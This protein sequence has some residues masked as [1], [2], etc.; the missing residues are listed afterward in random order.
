MSLRQIDYVCVYRCAP[1]AQFLHA[2]VPLEPAVRTLWSWTSL[3][4][5]HAGNVHEREPHVCDPSRHTHPHPLSRFPHTPTDPLRRWLGAR[6]R[7]RGSHG[8]G[9]ITQHETEDGAAFHIAHL[10]HRRNVE[11][12]IPSPLVTS[13]R[14]GG[15]GSR[16]HREADRSRRFPAISCR[17]ARARAGVG[18]SDR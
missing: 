15:G 12:E 18:G 17:P 3:T 9:L 2:V 1:H 14:G 4:L 7:A 16:D 8:S 10:L 6:I 5:T 11:P 13:E